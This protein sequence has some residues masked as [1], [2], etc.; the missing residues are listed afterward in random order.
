MLAQNILIMNFLAANHII[1]FDNIFDQIAMVNFQIS[2]KINAKFT[3]SFLFQKQAIHR[4][5]RM[6]Q[7]KH[8]FIY[9][10]IVSCSHEEKEFEDY[11]HGKLVRMISSK[12][13]S[14]LNDIRPWLDTSAEIVG[15]VQH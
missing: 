3:L 7:K 10:F 8:C 1:L 9:R 12:M 15:N 6:G 11:I 4:V 5:Y 13:N 2:L 14:I